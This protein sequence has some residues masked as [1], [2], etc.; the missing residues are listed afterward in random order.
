[1]STI[2]EQVNAMVKNPQWDKDINFLY[3]LKGR[4]VEEGGCGDIEPNEDFADYINAAKKC[5]KSFKVDRLTKG[6]RVF[7]TVNN[8]KFKLSLLAKKWTI[9]KL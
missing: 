1:M 6:F 5:V 3:E 8:V 9:T 4:W 7:F 2:R